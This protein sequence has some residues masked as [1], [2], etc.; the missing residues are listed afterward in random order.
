[1]PLSSTPPACRPT[2]PLRTL[3]RRSS[4]IKAWLPAHKTAIYNVYTGA[5]PSLPNGGLDR[6]RRA[7]SS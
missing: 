2:A 4:H 7:T 5:R 3:A 6:H 1:M